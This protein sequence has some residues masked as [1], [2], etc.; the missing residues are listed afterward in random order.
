MESSIVNLPRSSPHL[1]PLLAL[2]TSGESFQLALATA[3]GQWAYQYSVTLGQKLSHSAVLMPQAALALQ[4]AGL[5]AKQLKSVAVC[6]GPGSF[7]GIRTGVCSVR[8]LLQAL[9]PLQVYGFNTLEL[10]AT[11][12]LKTSPESLNSL[13]N[14]P[15]Y[16]LTDARRG[17]AYVASFLCDE[18]GALQ[19]LAEPTLQA[20]EAFAEDLTVKAQPFVLLAPYALLEKLSPLLWP[21][22][23]QGLCYCHAYT[24]VKQSP[25]AMLNL[26]LAGKRSSLQLDELLPLYLQQPNITLKSPVKP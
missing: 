4:T 15:L 8:G 26:L 6:L 23:S 24:D 14:K 16:A 19:P 10:L 9:P 7:T 1:F 13:K 3:S 25:Q 22:L 5:Q 18:L 11:Q 17:F 21:L 2:D 20:Y 12:H